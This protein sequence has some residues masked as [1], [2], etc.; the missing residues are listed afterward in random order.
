MSGPK[1]RAHRNDVTPWS[2]DGGRR[3][4]TRAI[5]A[6]AA[7]AKKNSPSRWRFRP[8]LPGTFGFRL[9]PSG[10][11]ST[12]SRS[13]LGAR[14]KI[15]PSRRACKSAWRAFRAICERFRLLRPP[16][17]FVLRASGPRENSPS[18]WRFRP[19][20]PGTFGFRLR[21]SGAAS[22]YSRSV[23][24]ARANV[25]R[26]PRSDKPRPSRFCRI[27]RALNCPHFHG[28]SRVLGT[29]LWITGWDGGGTRRADFRQLD[30]TSTIVHSRLDV[31]WL[32]A[33]A[34]R[35]VV[36][37]RAGDRHPPAERRPAAARRRGGGTRLRPAVG[38]QRAARAARPRP[39]R[40]RGA[41]PRARD[42]PDRRRQRRHRG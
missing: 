26:R 30:I 11:A 12:Y 32:A 25:R 16:R 14:G 9:R 28:F 35:P 39:A 15:G 13:V 41:L 33:E 17:P 6:G 29:T 4:G 37:D 36:R 10:A 38:A 19:P 23:L 34:A 27:L 40:D 21:P 20:L 8:P 31:V 5:L 7:V 24:G 1:K 18:R 22:T 42:P 3:C 2:I